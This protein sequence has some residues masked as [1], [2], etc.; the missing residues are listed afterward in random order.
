MAS[1]AE[2]DDYETHMA[3]RAR[4]EAVAEIPAPADRAW[5]SVDFVPSVK[6]PHIESDYVPLTRPVLTTIAG[7]G[8]CDVTGLYVVRYYGLANQG[9]S[10]I[11]A[12]V[13]AILAAFPV[14]SLGRLPSGNPLRIRGGL[15]DVSPSPGQI[16]P[17][18]NNKSRCTITIPWRCQ[19]LN[20][21]AASVA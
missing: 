20:P 9:E 15:N 21:V 2:F 7:G 1:L 17:V 12:V 3:L 18:G 6:R 10:L 5:N 8:V 11:W 14:G 13:R 4:L 19:A 16:L